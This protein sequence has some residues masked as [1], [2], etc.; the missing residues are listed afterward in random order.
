MGD[1]SA[2]VFVSFYSQSVSQS[3][4][5]VNKIIGFRDPESGQEEKRRSIGRHMW[6]TSRHLEGGTAKIRFVMGSGR[7]W[8]I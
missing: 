1:P 7:V 6:L 4:S 5:F 2:R 3:V 8:R